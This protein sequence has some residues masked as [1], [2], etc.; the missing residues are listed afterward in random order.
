VGIILAKLRSKLLEQLHV[1]HPGIWWMKT[2]VRSY[3]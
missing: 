3:L 1:D 2:V